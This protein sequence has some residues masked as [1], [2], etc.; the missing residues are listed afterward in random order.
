[1]VGV[2]LGGALV[3]GGRL[4]VAAEGIKRSAA[5]VEKLSLVGMLRRQALSNREGL[6]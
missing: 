5:Q 6:E 1:V 3:L 2:E 4:L